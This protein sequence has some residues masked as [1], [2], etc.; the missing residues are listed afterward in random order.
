MILT[1][2]VDIQKD[3]LAYEVAGWG[4]GFESWGAELYGDPRR[5]EV[6]NQLGALLADR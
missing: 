2:G 1:M 3:R 6:W 5:G 4:E